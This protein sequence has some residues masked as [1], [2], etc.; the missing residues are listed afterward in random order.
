MT[1]RGWE[2]AR[3]LARLEGISF[4]D[5]RHAAA[6]RL[7]AARMDGDF[8]A[9][10]MGHKDST[11]TRRVYSHLFDAPEKVQAVRDALAMGDAS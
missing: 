2:H 10:Q 4:H 7:I 8:V 9:A 1:R 6:S 5:L 11:V 3:K